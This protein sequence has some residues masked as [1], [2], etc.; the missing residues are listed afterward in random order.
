VAKYE[1]TVNNKRCWETFYQDSHG[2]PTVETCRNAEERGMWP[3]NDLALLP[4]YFL[5]E[6]IGPD[7]PDGNNGTVAPRVSTSGQSQSRPSCLCE[8]CGAAEIENLWEVVSA[9]ML[10]SPAR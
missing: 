4:Q 5:V 10:I 1:L 7:L 9:A 3:C 2:S 8:R 6:T